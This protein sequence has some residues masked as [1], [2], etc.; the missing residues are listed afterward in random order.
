MKKVG[1][2]GHFGFGLN[3]LN[4]Q[5]IKTKTI[6]DELTETFG[7]SQIMTVDT[8]GGKKALL[9]VAYKLFLMFKNCS[10]VIIMPAQNGLKFIVPL[11]Y[12][13]NIIFHRKML[14]IVIGGW[15]GNFLRTHKMLRKILKRFYRIYVETDEMVECLA[16]L[17]FDN[18]VRME[19]C[20]NI[21]IVSQNQLVLPNSEP[22]KVCT[23]SRVSKEKGVEIA[24]DA[25]QSINT[26]SQKILFELDIYGQVDESYKSRFSEL[27]LKFP[28]YIHYKGTV[29]Y[30]Q[31][32]DV[33]NGYAALLFPTYYSG[34]GFAG[35]LIDAMAAG[36]PVIASD[37]KYNNKIV[38]CGK[39]GMLLSQN[40][41]SALQESLLWVSHHIN[42][43]NAMKENCIEE[44]IKYLPST[45][46]SILIQDIA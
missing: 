7:E 16:D 43:W 21:K 2:C 38:H 29:G 37:W 26:K 35:T 31:S 42:E 6:T 12:I 3:L 18:V 27:Q 36:V 32:T 23:F 39:T 17:G 44:A 33:L 28:Q 15:I 45:V 14:Y 46:L 30:N 1:I 11:C 41:E 9:A 10:C 5:T 34:E 25:V 40:S 4:G 8:H 20:K 22:Y 13:F 19:N 24:I